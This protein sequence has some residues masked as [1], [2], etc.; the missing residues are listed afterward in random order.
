M[1]IAAMPPAMPPAVA[2]AFELCP[3]A[4]LGVAVFD[5]AIVDAT[6]FEVELPE[7]PG[8]DGPEGPSNVPGPSSGESIKVKRGSHGETVRGEETREVPT[9]DG[10]RFVEVPIVLILERVVSILSGKKA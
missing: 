6:L 7:L 5:A 2:P 4:G 3:P 10:I 1:E 9:T 8:T